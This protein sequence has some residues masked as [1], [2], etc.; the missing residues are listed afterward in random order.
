[1]FLQTPMDSEAA[2]RLYQRDRAGP[3]FVMNLTR[4][5]AWR[6]ATHT[7]FADLRNALTSRSTLTPRE[8][9]VIVCSAAASL[10]DAY[11]SLA[12]GARL[13]SA[14]DGATAAAV[15]A[16]AG[17]DA[18]TDRERALGT[19]V[20][21][22]VADPNG[23]TALDVHALRAAGLSEQEIFDATAQAAFRLAF[24]TVNDALGVVP[25]RQIAAAAPDEVRRAVTFGR[26]V[27]AAPG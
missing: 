9:A 7:A 14:S 6:P 4:L 22:V 8:Q 17:S 13:A 20:R 10:G 2:E 11:C 16:G 26:L 1:M 21:K 18:L 15:L 19:W 24:S 12:W 5:W 23:T 3:G 25:D 27:A